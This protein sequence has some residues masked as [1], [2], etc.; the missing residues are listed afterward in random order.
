MYESLRFGE[1]LSRRTART[2]MPKIEPSLTARAFL[3]LISGLGRLGH[4]SASLLVAAGVDPATLDDPDPRV[5][6]S[7]GVRLLALAA[8][9]TGDDCI[10]LHLAE[11]ADLRTADVHFYAMLASATL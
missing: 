1:S 6:M 11:H 10:G 8:E 7:A 3:P 2:T 5:P 4:D 9:T